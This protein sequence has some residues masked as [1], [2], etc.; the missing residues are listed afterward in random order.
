VA[1]VKAHRKP[2]EALVLAGVRSNVGLDSAVKGRDLEAL[3]YWPDPPP[4]LYISL[5]SPDQI[6][7]RRFWVLAAFGP[8]NLKDL[9]PV[10]ARFRAIAIE[11][12]HF[13]VTQGGCAYL[14]ERATPNS[15]R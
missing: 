13:I 4:P 6:A 7:Q 2:G 11:R 3:C 14:F 1:Y 10:L 8:D 5:S 9:A 15:V 12:D